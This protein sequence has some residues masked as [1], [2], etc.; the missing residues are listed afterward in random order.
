MGAVLRYAPN[1]DGSYTQLANVADG[2]TLHQ[3]YGVAVDAHGDVFIADA[4]NNQ[5][6]E[7]APSVTG[8]Y[9]KLS[10]VGQGLNSPHGVTL[11]GNGNVYIANTGSGQVV[12]DHFASLGRLTPEIAFN[13]NSC[14]SPSP[15][16]FSSPTDQ[17]TLIEIGGGCKHRQ[18]WEYM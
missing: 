8:G 2:S 15:E 16:V 14:V 6:H 12:K 17:P 18:R 11:D 4:P 3:P 10:D 1:S 5:V 13:W 9:N 7:Y